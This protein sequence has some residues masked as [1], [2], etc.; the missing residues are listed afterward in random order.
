M[1]SHLTQHR[2]HSHRAE[3]PC[4]QGG[5]SN[6]LEERGDRGAVGQSL[7]TGGAYEEKTDGFFSLYVCEEISYNSWETEKKVMTGCFILTPNHMSHPLGDCRSRHS[8][9]V[10]R[11]TLNCLEITI[12]SD[13]FRG[14]CSPGHD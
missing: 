13:C 1:S 5:N 6:Y 10:L 2:C 11:L 14:E 4:G 9:S 3:H 12:T 7:T 8:H